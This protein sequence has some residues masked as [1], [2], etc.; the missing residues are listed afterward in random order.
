MH[1][2][3]CVFEST[4]SLLLDIPSKIKDELIA[5][6]DLQDLEIRE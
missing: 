6:K 1:V 4:I 3:K 2:E 5:H